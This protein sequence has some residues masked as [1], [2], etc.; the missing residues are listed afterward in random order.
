MKTDEEDNSA[1]EEDNCDRKCEP[2][3]VSK[4]RYSL[5]PLNLF[6]ISFKPGANN[7]RIQ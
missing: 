2:N 4:G 1:D 6:F 5:G 3:C 7:G